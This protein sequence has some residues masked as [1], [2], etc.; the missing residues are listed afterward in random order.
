VLAQIF[1]K[2]ITIQMLH[3][4]LVAV[5]EVKTVAEVPQH[6]HRLTQDHYF[7]PAEILAADGKVNQST[8]QH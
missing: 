4:T 6:H 3:R 5:Q 8:F 1:A 7:L 2:A